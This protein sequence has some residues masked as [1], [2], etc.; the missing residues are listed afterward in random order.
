MASWGRCASTRDL[1]SDVRDISQLG[2]AASKI[3]VWM[4]T[5]NVN[6]R[7]STR[8][9]GSACEDQKLPWRGRRAGAVKIPGSK[10]PNLDQCISLTPGEKGM[11]PVT[12]ATGTSHAAAAAATPTPPATRGVGKTAVVEG[13]AM[14]VVKGEVPISLRNI[15][16][17]SLDLGFG[18][19][20]AS[21]RKLLKALIQE[22]KS[23]PTPLFCS[24][25]KPDTL[26]GAGASGHTRPTCSSPRWPAAK[27][28][29]RPPR[30]WNTRNTSAS[31]K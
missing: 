28:A 6:N 10:T 20:K 22:V 5:S 4:S 31:R 12:A 3:N 14:A 15:E 7:S 11:D 21:S 30:A 18:A 2:N 17:R 8:R 13:F 9:A 19:L 27:C 26:I 23:S 29:P 24:S 1:L 25:T 16:I